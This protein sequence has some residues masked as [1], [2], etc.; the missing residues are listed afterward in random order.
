[1]KKTLLL[2]VLLMPGI[3]WAKDVPR[4]AGK[5]EAACKVWTAWDAAG[6]Q[7]P[8]VLTPEATKTIVGSTVCITYLLGWYDG[9]EG[10][11]A[12]DDKGVMGV[13]SF[14]D[15]VTAPQMAKD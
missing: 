2:L 3:M 12:P 15:G 10:A 13:A 14:P 5:L 1:M 11:L 9:V 6:R 4:A 7:N 8:K